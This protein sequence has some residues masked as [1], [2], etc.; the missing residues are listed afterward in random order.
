ME[1]D[2]N[3]A[4][5]RPVAVGA[6]VLLLGLVAGALVPHL[7]RTCKCTRNRAHLGTLLVL[8]VVLLWT[9]SSLA[10][11]HVFESYH[12]RKPFFL[13]YFST[14]SFIVYL[15]FYPDRVRTL[16][17]ALAGR[18]PT[19]ELVT[20]GG[21]SSRPG[22]ERPRTA[23]PT[24]CEELGLATRLGLLF[25]AYQ[26]SFVIGLEL[27]TVSVATVLSASS[28]LFTLFFSAVRLNERVG[29]VKLASTVLSFC[30]VLLVVRYG[31]PLRGA[32]QPIGVS[33]RLREP[34]PERRPSI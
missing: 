30:G 21:A 19:Y 1:A 2:E 32:R 10:V 23:P 29:A 11:Q 3:L 5:Y 12:Y 33:P 13:T 27:T 25:F 4:V 22:D 15:P 8:V 6:G 9:G 17:A 34:E 16:L 31:D 24:P 26:V 28:G 14:S 20:S 7:W 18:P